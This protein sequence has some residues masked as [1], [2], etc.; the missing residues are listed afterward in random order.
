M[1]EYFETLTIFSCT[2]PLNPKGGPLVHS[3]YTK[4]TND[5][6]SSL[7]WVTKEEQVQYFQYFVHKKKKSF[8]VNFKGLR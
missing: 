3:F 5:I 8:G 2:Q 6:K 1:V 4:I 7:K